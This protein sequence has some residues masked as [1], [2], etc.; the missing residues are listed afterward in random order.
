MLQGKKEMVKKPGSSSKTTAGSRA[1][2]RELIP[3]PT[4]A[5]RGKELGQGGFIQDLRDTWH[6]VSPHPKV[7][8]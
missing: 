5:P 1:W 3:G 2:P 7:K 8:C 6:Q 4:A